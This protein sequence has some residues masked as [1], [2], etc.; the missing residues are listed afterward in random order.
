MPENKPR[1]LNEILDLFAPPGANDSRWFLFE[2]QL[3]QIRISAMT[4][5][6]TLE[7][8]AARPEN[9]QE[10]VAAQDC[11]EYCKAMLTKI[12]GHRAS[13]HSYLSDTDV[14]ERISRKEV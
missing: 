14:P 12:L 4:C 2:H 6:G 7:L 3:E 11:L 10:R 8:I 13:I 9:H 1:S 5:A